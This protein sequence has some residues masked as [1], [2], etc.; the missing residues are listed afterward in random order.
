YEES[1]GP[2]HKAQRNLPDLFTGL[3]ALLSG[4]P[5]Q[6][7]RAKRIRSLTDEMLAQLDRILVLVRQ[8]REQLANLPQGQKRANPL[9]GKWLQEL[10]SLLAEEDR[11]LESRIAQSRHAQQV[12]KWS[13]GLSLLLGISGAVVAVRLFTS[14]ITNR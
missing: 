3:E 4:D 14:G 2:Y 12:F 8:N 11:L 5:G 10:D 7:A 13:I 1:L 6:S 9:A